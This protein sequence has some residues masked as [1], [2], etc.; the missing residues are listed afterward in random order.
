MSHNYFNICLDSWSHSF[1]CFCN[2]QNV[3]IDSQVY[4]N[5]FCNY[6]FNTYLR[7]WSHF[8]FVDFMITKIFWSIYFLVIFRYTKMT[9]VILKLICNTTRVVWTIE[10]IL[11]VACS[12]TK[13]FWPLHSL[14]IFTYTK[15][16]TVI[17]RWVGEKFGLVKHI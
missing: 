3:L 13:T 8:I 11:F 4:K 17:L 1:L 9:L 14:V 6:H 10:L 2:Y 12:I 7:Y 16:P 15:S 5:N